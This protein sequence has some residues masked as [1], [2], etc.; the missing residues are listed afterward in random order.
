M[1]YG[2]QIVDD[3]LRRNIVPIA[4]QIISKAFR[5]NPQRIS[6]GFWNR[7]TQSLPVRA[8]IVVV[9]LLSICDSWSTYAADWTNCDIELGRLS[10]H[11]RDAELSASNLAQL[12][13]ALTMEKD[14][15]QQCLNYPEMYDLLEDGCSN[16]RSSVNL[17]VAEYNNALQTLDL[18]IQ[19]ML[20]RLKSILLYCGYKE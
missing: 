3:S 10:R 18:D 17:K 14:N 16:K 13:S 4:A 19:P 9:L 1:P 5:M 7:L 20:A 12:E 8:P 15:L 11:A 2:V 6:A